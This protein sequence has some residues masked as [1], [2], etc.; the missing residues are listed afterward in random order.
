MTDIFHERRSIRRFETRAVEDAKLKAIFEAAR[1]SPSWGN[2]QCAELVVITGAESK[3]YLSSLLSPK[4]PATLSVANAPVVIGVCGAPKKS[5]YYKDVQSTRYEH[6][7]MYDV[8]IV[9]Q[10]IC[11]KACELGLGTVIVGSFDHQKVEEH[12]Q[13]PGGVELVALI[14]LGYPA[15]APS[16]PQRKGMEEFIHHE[17]F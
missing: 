3:Q 5:G 2:L 6:W 16:A 11:L 17:H 12:L 8:G 15:H 10:T 1:M 13:V 7:F 9:S 4:N 14:P